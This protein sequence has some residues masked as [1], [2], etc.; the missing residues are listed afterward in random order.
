MSGSVSSL[1]SGMV[2]GLMSLEDSRHPG[3]G[4]TD[5]GIRDVVFDRSGN[6]EKQSIWNRRCWK[7]LSILLR[8]QYPTMRL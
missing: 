5:T 7:V 8:S 3:P 2:D 1:S 6:A 4:G